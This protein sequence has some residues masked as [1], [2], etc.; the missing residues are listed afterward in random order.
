MLP[1]MAVMM[2]IN[3][4]HLCN[5]ESP[6]PFPSIESVARDESVPCI[7][8]KEI[9]PKASAECETNMPAA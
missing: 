7:A 8:I 9:A 6:L 2:P 1:M 4:L 3:E 5:C